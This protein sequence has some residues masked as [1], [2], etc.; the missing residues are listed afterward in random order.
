MCVA[1]VVMLVAAGAP[2]VYLHHPD[3]GRLVTINARGC[4]YAF[5]EM[6]PLPHNLA[7]LT[8]LNAAGVVL[9]RTCSSGV[10]VAA[11]GWRKL[12]F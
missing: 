9:G 11:M 7:A 8:I 2:S 5:V 4:L 12:P 3:A 1:N 6:I 10:V